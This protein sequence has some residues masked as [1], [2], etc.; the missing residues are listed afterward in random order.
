[1]NSPNPLFL[2]TQSVVPDFLHWRARAQQRAR[3]MRL[4]EASPDADLRADPRQALAARVERDVTGRLR[5]RGYYVTRTGHQVSFDLLANGV[6]VEVKAATW[7]SGRY[8]AAL[9]SNQADVL[10][11]GCQVP[12][13]L[14]GRG[15]G[16]EGFTYFIIPFT[17][18]RGLRNFAIWSLD[19]ERSQGRWSRWLEAWPVIDDLIARGV[20]HWQMP[21]W[22][23]P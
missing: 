5:D 12:L 13:S 8:Q 19:P 23:A 18:V 17:E 7:S 3:Y 20:N 1:M 14:Q 2:A 22:N 21:L 6:R 11:L 9:R 10:V 15:A 16:G 4:C